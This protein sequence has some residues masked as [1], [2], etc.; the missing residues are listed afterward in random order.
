MGK[1]NYKPE[2]HGYMPL[3]PV[4]EDGEMIMPLQ[5]DE[6]VNLRDKFAPWEE[7]P[8]APESIA[9][10]AESEVE[11]PEVAAATIPEVD[12]T[13][14]AVPEVPKVELN[15]ASG[16]SV[17]GARIGAKAAA[18]G[19][20]VKGASLIAKAKMAAAGDKMKKNP[21]AAIAGA[22][23]VAVV[24]ALVALTF[25]WTRPA[26]DVVRPDSIGN[27]EDDAP[28]LPDG[29]TVESPAQIAEL[30][31][32][33]DRNRDAFYGFRN[34]D[35]KAIER[36]IIFTAQNIPDKIFV[37]NTFTFAD[38]SVVAARSAEFQRLFNAR[39]PFNTRGFEAH[40][41]HSKS[42]GIQMA[43]STYLL[44]ER[45]NDD[46]LRQFG[47]QPDEQPDGTLVANY[48]REE[49]ERRWVADGFRCTDTRVA[50]R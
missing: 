10:E 9:N 32:T 7:K 12:A 46:Q 25:V 36:R 1:K 2:E 20:A 45:L 44:N 15:R 13:P 6:Q 41:S 48:T 40:W 18:A 19:A 14:D 3:P 24:V 23:G 28:E 29:E 5:Q 35:N 31:C 8:A 17:V 11:A 50:Q 16:L 26:G 22:A 21:A 42:G 43:L 37:T 47:L 38:P 39:Y 30:V 4:D 33:A 34:F 27:E 49:L